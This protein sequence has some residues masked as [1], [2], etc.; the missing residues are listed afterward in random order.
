M[1]LFSALWSVV[2]PILSLVAEMFK[3]IASI[4]KWIWD[5][6][7]A[8]LVEWIMGAFANALESLSDALS[9]VAGWFETIGGW[10][11]TAKGYISQFADY[12]SG[13]KLPDWVTSGISTVVKTVGNF[14]GAEGDG[15]FAS[16]YHGLSNVPYDGYSARLHK[17]ERVLT[18]QENKEYSEG[19]RVVSPVINI[20]HMEV[21]KD[22]DIEAVAY[23]LAKYIEREA[24]QVAL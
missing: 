20:A 17:G 4:I 6:V 22:S 23:K 14:I 18:A 2:G 21:R 19:G 16:H 10:A 24:R 11:E 8:P 9:I 3:L 7:L 5:N 12:I 15:K 1:Q 13:I